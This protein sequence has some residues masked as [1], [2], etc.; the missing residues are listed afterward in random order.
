MHKQTN[1]QTENDPRWRLL[2]WSKTG[3]NTETILL[4]ATQD[5]QFQKNFSS[6]L[7]LEEYE[8][9]V[10]FMASGLPDEV[11]VEGRE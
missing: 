1:K 2:Q 6:P 9:L 10:V 5:P 7:I 4:A 3:Q 11:L 8:P